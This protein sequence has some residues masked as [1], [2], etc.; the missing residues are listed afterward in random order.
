MRENE[1]DSEGEQPGPYD[2][3][4]PW[5]AYDPDE[6]GPPYAAGT[7]PRDSI[8][9]GKP[10]DEDG[11]GS[12]EQRGYSDPW[13][14][15]GYGSGDRYRSG[16]W[17][18]GPAPRRARRRGH[19]RVYLTV[20]AV[21]A[22]VG[23]GLTVAFGS[24]GSSPA[25]SI[26]SPGIPSPQDDAPGSGSA[27]NAAAVKHKVA[28][29]L[30]D[31]TATLKYASETAEGT[32]MVVSPSGLVLTNN[33]VIDGATAVTVALADNV[34]RTYQAQVIGYDS[35]DDVALLQLT[36]ASGLATVSIG[37]SAQVRVGTQ[38]LALGDAQGRGGVTPARGYISGL[39]RSIQATDQGSGSTENLNHMLQ[40][41]AQIQ[42]GDSGGALANSAGQVIGMVTAANTPS[43]GQPGDS[44][45]FAIPINTALTIAQKIAAGKPS[46]TVYIG[47]P[48]FLGVEVAQSNSADPQQQ[49]ADERRSSGDAGGGNQGRTGC[50][51]DG[52]EP[53]V[54]HRIAPAASGALI[55]GVLC[56]TAAQSRGL[57]AGD[58]VLSVDGQVVT[59]PDSLTTITAKYHPGGVVSVTWVAINGSRHTARIVL[60]PGP[61]R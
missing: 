33:H 15:S 12:Y 43:A 10:A 49:A 32:G 34:H 2:D 25:A 50:V 35:A 16:G 47:L 20:A 41:T 44:E 29:G 58:V 4:S 6:A 23:A 60:G 42:Q 56:E 5:A 14:S 30:V 28:P 22:V 26:S 13:Y 31:I 38:V 7:D 55:V 18:P 1:S 21:A 57:V 53:G 54:P 51:A 17:D 61:A 9:F 59:T 52:Q 19:L 27:L 24:S 3:I 36:G 37:N 48:G 11:Q 40:T 39:N 45:G 8:A 46:A